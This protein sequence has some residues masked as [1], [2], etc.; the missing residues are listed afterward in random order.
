MSRL[1]LITCCAVALLLGGLLSRAQSSGEPPLKTGDIVFHT[2]R[3]TQS[4]AIQLA[5][6]SPYS[7]VGVVEVT[8]QGAFVIEAI[9]PV[10]RTPWAKWRRRSIDERVLVKRLPGLSAAQ[11]RRV[12][13]TAGSMLGRP[14]DAAF[15]W[16]DQRLYCS[17]LVRKVFGRGAGIELGRM[18]RLGSLKLG[19]IGPALRQRYGGRV[20]L[21][22]Q[23]VTPASIADDRRLETVWSSY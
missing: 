9:Q 11:A 6:G 2:S 10:S 15:A 14:Y 13:E 12:I 22:R 19:L 3:S 16:D 18:E 8:P 17:E 20:P 5:T 4:R 23:L 7:H 21:D 1:T